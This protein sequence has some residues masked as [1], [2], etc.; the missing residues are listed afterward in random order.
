[1][2]ETRYADDTTFTGA[3]IW[4]SFCRIVMTGDDS[5]HSPVPYASFALTR[6]FA[7]VVSG[8]EGTGA[9]IGER[10]KFV[11]KEIHLASTGLYISASNVIESPS[12]SVAVNGIE[13]LSPTVNV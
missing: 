4:P 1:M 11:P 8:I 12:T 5:A 13:M 7:L 3:R 9:T 6:Y 10:V 2:R